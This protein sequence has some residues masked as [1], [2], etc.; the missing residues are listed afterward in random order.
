MSYDYLRQ[1]YHVNAYP[2]DLPVNV[3][4]ENINKRTYRALNYQTNDAQQAGNVPDDQ[5]SKVGATVDWDKPFQISNVRSEEMLEDKLIALKAWRMAYQE[6][7]KA[8]ESPEQQAKVRFNR[9]VDDKFVFDGIWWHGHGIMNGG[10]LVDNAALA[11]TLTVGKYYNAFTDGAAGRMY[12]SV[13]NEQGGQ[14]VFFRS[15]ISLSA[16]G[17]P[18]P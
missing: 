2:L 8:V 5:F 12:L 1:P 14:S 18:I 11:A 15:S 13:T 4:G 17:V 10:P 6:I 16:E 3:N 9:M 7:S